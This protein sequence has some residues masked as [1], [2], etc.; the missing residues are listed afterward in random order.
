MRCHITAFE[1]MA[2]CCSEILYDRM[3]LIATEM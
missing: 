1:A 3:M 2:G